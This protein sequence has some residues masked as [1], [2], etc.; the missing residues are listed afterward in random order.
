MEQRI[1]TS[2]E[3]RLTRAVEKA[4]SLAAV[5]ESH[6]R[7]KLL[8]D[9]LRC[10]QV[11]RRFAKTAAQA[12][13]KRLTVLTLQKT[14]DE[15]K[16]DAFQLVDP[17]TVY[18]M[19]GGEPD[20]E[21]AA[22]VKHE[23]AASFTPNTMEKA[24]SAVG[25]S[26]PLYEDTVGL[27]TWLEHVESTLEKQAAAFSELNGIYES[28]DSDIRE[29]RESLGQ[30]LV[31]RLKSPGYERL[32]Q[33]P[34]LEATFGGG[35]ANVSVSLANYGLDTAFVTVLPDNDICNKVAKLLDDIDSQKAIGEFLV[36][37][38]EG[39]AEFSKT[40]A[41][42]GTMLERLG[43]MGKRAD[44]EDKDLAMLTDTALSL[45]IGAYD[46]ATKGLSYLGGNVYGTASKLLNNA[47][48]KYYAA[49]DLDVSPGRVLDAGFIN[50]DRMRDRM[51]AWSDMTADPA[52]SAYPSSQLFQATNKAMNTDLSLER[53]DKREVLRATV[54]QLL[55]QNNRHSTADIAALAST[56]KSLSSSVPT[57]AVQTAEDVRG[58]S[59]VSAW[60]R[61][62]AA[63]LAGQ[64]LLRR[65]Q[66][67]GDFPGGAAFLGGTGDQRYPRQRNGLLFRMHAGL[68]FL[69][70][71]RDF[72][73]TARKGC[74]SARTGGRDE[75]AGTARGAQHQ[76]C[77]RHPLSA[78]H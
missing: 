23:F 70:E 62:N 73:R 77:D 33:S 74:H 48:E 67:S 55:A 45:P 60:L 12:F 6:E 8:A 39:L 66:Y 28:L 15:H 47:R 11:D 36:Q 20:L 16:A 61:G 1:S 13:N 46:L 50:D 14:A 54:A 2:D 24:A 5:N 25:C 52:F 9:Q 49:R 21:K 41:D 35:E 4:A 7:N 78:S 72:S 40:A 26:R 37:Y 59:A 22:S 58:L 3:Q 53:A 38:K 71:C 51:M 44:F 10:E 65:R 32:M 31:L 75:V 57:A 43:H 63:G 17:Q 56:L 34:V 19:L 42:T 76:L 64:R 29:R 18:E 30:E 68:Y 27:D 69:S